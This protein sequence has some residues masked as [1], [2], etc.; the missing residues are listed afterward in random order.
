M[1]R[2][3]VIATRNP[4]KLREIAHFFQNLPVDLRGLADFSY[5]PP[6]VEDRAT[7]YENALKK[8]IETAQHIKQWVLADDTA[9]EVEAL[10]G[11]PGVHSARYSGAGAT[12]ESNVRKLL[13]ELSGVPFEKRQ[14]LFRSVI[15]LR[16]ENSL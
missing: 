7:T 11:A 12:Y 2:L 16:L 13:S 8:A 4:D 14:A 15:A 10:K 3:L 5:M 1:S 6:V 9:L